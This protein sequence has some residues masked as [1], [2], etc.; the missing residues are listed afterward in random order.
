MP[1]SE[2]IAGL[3]VHI[4]H[5][6]LLLPSVSAVVFNDA[7]EILLGR[8]SDNGKWSLIAGV[9]DPGEQPADAVIR[10]VREETGVEAVVERLIGVALHPVVYPNGD[11]CEYLDV[12]FRCQAVGGRAQ[13][14]DDESLAVEWFPVDALPALDP[15]VRLRIE[16]A[17]KDEPSAWYAPPGV[18][19]PELTH[20]DGI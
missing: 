14:N 15:W 2:Y 5:D 11:R 8:R 3:R 7:G 16:K 13:V 9:L 4:G 6:L 20:P 12:W 19:Q 17:L 18:V 10:E 1:V